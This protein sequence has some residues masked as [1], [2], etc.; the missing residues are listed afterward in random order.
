MDSFKL[1]APDSDPNDLALQRWGIIAPAGPAGDAAL[2]ALAPLIRLREGEQA[3]KVKI[4]R[5]APLQAN[6]TDAFRWK[7]D[8]WQ[9]EEE[10]ERPRYLVLVGDADQLSFELQHV[11]SSGALV[12]RVHAPT[13]DGYASYAE[14]VVRW[15]QRPSTE[16]R[17]DALFF[18]TDDET[19][20]TAVGRA[21]LIEP[22]LE[23]ARAGK[24]FPAR[25]VTQLSTP[26]T[27]LDFLRAAERPAPAVLLSVS[28]GLGPPQRG[29]ADRG[30]QRRLQGALLVT[31]EGLTA[32]DRLV[33]AEHL[34]GRPFLRGGLWFCLACFGAGTPRTSSFEPWL[35]QLQATADYADPAARLL[36]R[37]PTGNDP[38]FVA[39]LPQ[40]ALANPDGPLAV[41][42]HVDLAWT[43][44][45]TD[46]EQPTQ[47]RAARIFSSIQ[48][49]VRG[50][51]AGVALGA[52]MRSYRQVNDELT[53]MYEE[54]EKARLWQRPNPIRPGELARAFMVRN[55]LRGYILVGDPA[56]RLPLAAAPA[57]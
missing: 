4:Y 57:A 37:L 55:D 1:E 35:S 12:G 11:L 10:S 39:A 22:C 23:L 17:P 44:G 6:L 14:K 8:I 5:N 40:M 56:V 25:E 7:N 45:F 41:I 54:I 32:Q 31:G 9:Q 24:R 15:A 38:P 21:L 46:R 47:S 27:A 26:Q 30:E 52:L 3:A 33:T 29:W 43:Y 28:H 53:D 16:A 13:L 48:V 34:Q 36:D 19:E 49:M 42:G 18:V 51:R 2:A 50:S 20:A